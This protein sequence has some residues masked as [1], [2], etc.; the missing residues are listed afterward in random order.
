MEN[1]D[2]TQ[3]CPTCHL[4][5]NRGV[6]ID[7]VIIKDNQILLVQRGAEPFKGY[8]ATPGGY[9]SWNESA[10]QTVIREV[11]EETNLDV[12][13]PRLVAVHSD[14]HR[15]PKQ[16]INL[17]YYVSEVSG[18]LKHGDD[19]LDARWFPLDEIPNELALDH[20]T[21]IKETIEKYISS[22]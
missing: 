22:V 4:Y 19:A 3:P 5:P 12:T 9:I 15:H 2:Q 18:D 20:A 8:W 11:K 14:P 10:E 1:Q 17:V 21:N 13:N 16:V 7:A 6:S